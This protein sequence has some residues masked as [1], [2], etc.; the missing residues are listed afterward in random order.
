MH[1][2]DLGGMLQTNKLIPTND[3]DPVT[4]AVCAHFK[5]N[6]AVL[7]NSAFVICNGP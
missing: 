4:S 1:A 7:T 5:T 3:P 2:T 6:K